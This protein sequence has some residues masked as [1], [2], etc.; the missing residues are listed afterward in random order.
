MLRTR[1][2]KH[3]VV[4]MVALIII[5]LSALYISKVD[6][7]ARWQTGAK[8][9]TGNLAINFAGETYL[10]DKNGNTMKLSM[11]AKMGI[12]PLAFFRGQAEV[13][14]MVVRISWTATG[15]DVD[16][17]T[18]KINWS[19]SGTGGFRRTGQ[20]KTPSGII[21]IKLPITTT[22]LGRTPTSGETIKWNM[23]IWISASILDKVG[24]TLTASP[25][26][27]TASVETVWYAPNFSISASSSTTT[28]VTTAT[29]GCGLL[30]Q[31]AIW[32]YNVQAEPTVVDYAVP[33]VQG[34]LVLAVVSLFITVFAEKLKVTGRSNNES[35]Q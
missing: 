20:E 25:A 15:T 33:M 17:A 23:T 13:T 10:L 30:G 21:E 27:I 6:V 24:R 28:D 9:V 31:H 2:Q 4:V 5:I 32:V 7:L 3:L 35:K 14:A 26:P 1:R 11:A 16:W 19:A 18:L 12:F 34:I 8:D 29:G 22:Q